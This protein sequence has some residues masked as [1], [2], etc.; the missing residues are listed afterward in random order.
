MLFYICNCLNW[1]I[2]VISMTTNSKNS[3]LI[4][5][6]LP[7]EKIENWLG[8]KN[9][10]NMWYIILFLDYS[11]MHVIHIYSIYKSFPGQFR[12]HPQFLPYFFLSFFL[13]LFIFFHLS[14]LIQFVSDFVRALD[15]SRLVLWAL[16][17]KFVVCVLVLNVCVC[18]RMHIGN[19]FLLHLL[20]TLNALTLLLFQLIE[21]V[22]SNKN[23]NT[24]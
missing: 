19:F 3:K 21:F 8:S 6:I 24:K 12:L 2:C 20:H 5:T 23:E 15:I 10:W 17:Q 22:P 18:V 11:I 4:K 16:F 14:L 9:R 7:F 1:K 13:S